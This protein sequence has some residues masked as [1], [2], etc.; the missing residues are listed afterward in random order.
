MRIAYWITMATNSHS[1]YVILIAFPRQ[2]WLR[3]RN[4]VLRNT[5]IA[6]LVLC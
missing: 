4:S 5:Y 1:E 2:Q 6:Y 3:E